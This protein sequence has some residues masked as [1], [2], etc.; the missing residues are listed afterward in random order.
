MREFPQRDLRTCVLVELL[1]LQ[2]LASRQVS[3]VGDDRK[4]MI[5]HIEE[6]LEVGS[7]WKDPFRFSAGVTDL[8]YGFY[9]DSMSHKGQVVCYTRLK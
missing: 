1:L 2:L 6:E 5:R 9:G 4:E 3:Q 8:F 7:L